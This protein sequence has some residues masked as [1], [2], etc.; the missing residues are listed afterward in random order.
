MTKKIKI[1]DKYIGGES[2]ILGSLTPKTK[3][4]LRKP[5]DG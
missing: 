2:K 4:N 3:N 5:H 1:K